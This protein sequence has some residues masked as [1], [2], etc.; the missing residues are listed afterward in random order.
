MSNSTSI[1]TL[2]GLAN[3][4]DS[5][6]QYALGLAYEIGEHTSKDLAK[7]FE[8]Y[9]KSAA[10]DHPKAQYHLGI[11]YALAKGGAKKD[12]AQSKLWL[13]KA[14]ENGYLGGIPL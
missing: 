2:I 12:I 14:K 4:G 5:E 7:A 8:W 9:Q 3:Q 6:A 10:Q 11:F 1:Q 13:R